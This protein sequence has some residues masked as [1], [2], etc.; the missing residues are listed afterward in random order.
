MPEKNDIQRELSYLNEL[1]AKY[2]SWYIKKYFGFSLIQIA[3]EIGLKP[4]FFTAILKGQ[5]KMPEKYH[6]KFIE[7]FNQM[8]IIEKTKDFK[9]SPEQLENKRLWQGVKFSLTKSLFFYILITMKSLYYISAKLV[10]KQL[11]SSF[12]KA[13][14]D[15][16]LTFVFSF[17][18]ALAIRIRQI[19]NSVSNN[20]EAEFFCL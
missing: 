3:R 8:K 16:L 17:Y 19:L 11:L 20:I 14:V 12:F 2:G 13:R 4:N 1:R 6:Q 9:E 10:G 18:N 5:C 15:F 7:V